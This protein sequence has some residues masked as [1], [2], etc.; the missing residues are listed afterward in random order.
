MH[1]G[2]GAISKHHCSGSGISKRYRSRS[3]G[4]RPA[5]CRRQERR[6]RDGRWPQRRLGYCLVKGVRKYSSTSCCSCPYGMCDTNS[7]TNHNHADTLINCYRYRHS[8]GDRNRNGHAI[9]NGDKDRNRSSVSESERNFY[10]DGASVG[11]CHFDRNG[12][13]NINEHLNTGARGFAKSD[14]D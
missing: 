9:S 5:R 6:N 4:R 10:G 13:G 11:N 7:G 12:Y 2:P 3:I 14:P 1:S 8:D